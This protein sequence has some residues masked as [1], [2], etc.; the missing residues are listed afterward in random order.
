MGPS[1]AAPR[2][3]P[4]RTDR[5]SAR[6][7]T[8]NTRF[9]DL[10]RGELMVD[11]S[12]IDDLIIQRSDGT[13]TYNLTVV[14][15][16][17][18]MNISHVIRGDDHISNTFKQVNIFNALGYSLPEFAHV[19]MILGED[20]ARL[21]KRHGAVSVLEYERQGY[22]PEALL[23]YL[24]R[25]GWSHGDQELFTRDQMIELFDVKDVNKAASS[26]NVS[27]LNWLNQQY[28]KRCDIDRLAKLLAVHLQRRGIE[29]SNG[30]DLAQVAKIY[31][32]RAETLEKLADQ[33]AYL[34]EDFDAY[35]ETAAKKFLRPVSIEPVKHFHA[36]LEQLEDWQVHRIEAAVEDTLE[37]FELK[38]PKLAQP[39]RVAVTG[40]SSSPS[41]GQTLS[42]AGKALALKRISQ[43][44]EFMENRQRQAARNE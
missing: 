17:A 15:D 13:P 7:T 2:T 6:P 16:D 25:L 22:L 21:S 33:V 24:V 8:G 30:P 3:A 29:H 20:G 1:S 9:T 31:Q 44:I 41:I 27:K 5:R 23:N 18:D 19:P 40:S 28:I 38:M 39:I 37:K 14:V 10:I 26:F 32:E 4:P 35:D 34:F 42:V 43:A 11:N 12:E 36:A